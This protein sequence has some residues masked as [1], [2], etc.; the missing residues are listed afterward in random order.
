MTQ[1]LISVRNVREARLVREFEI[2][3]LDVKEPSRGGLGASD[4]E[5]LSSI[6]RDIASESNRNLYKS[7]SAGELFDW[8]PDVESDSKEQQPSS[9]SKWR[10]TS[11]LLTRY[12][13]ELLSE[14][15]FIKIG[16]A[17]V[18]TG[19]PPGVTNR[20]ATTWQ[21]DWR[22]LFNSLPPGLKSVAVVYLDFKTCDAPGP[23]EIIE[24]AAESDHC[25]TVLFDTCHKSGNLFSH[26]SISE[27]KDLVGKSATLGLRTVV[28]GSVSLP[29]LPEVLLLNPDYVGVRGAVCRQ[30]RESEIDRSKL[31][32]FVDALRSHI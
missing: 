4:P 19:K 1:L 21:T 12:G 18:A 22:N 11:A 27:L 3:I 9:D 32:E 17:G 24:L 13:Q 16:L 8:L 20:S 6:A 28:A 7:F 30:D 23:H 31:C 5:T 15:Q 2:G 10:L 14:F 29:C 25:R 26:T